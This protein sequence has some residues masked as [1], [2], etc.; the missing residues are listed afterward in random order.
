MCPGTSIA[1]L[2]QSIPGPRP[3]PE[4]GLASPLYLMLYEY[5]KGRVGHEM[6]L[7]ADWKLVAPFEADG[8]TVAMAS[9]FVECEKGK[10]KNL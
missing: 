3:V 10:G 5:E 2:Q 9:G 6:S 7:D 4:G 8:I 1:A